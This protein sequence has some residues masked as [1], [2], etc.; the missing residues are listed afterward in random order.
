MRRKLVISIILLIAIAAFSVLAGN[1]AIGTKDI[2]RVIAGGGSLSQQTI[3]FRVRLPRVAAAA[4]CGAALSVA[5]FIIQSTLD[6]RIAS[7]GILG[8]NNGAGLFVLISAL[9][10]PFQSGVKCIMAFA[11]AL[12]VA[13]LVSFLAVRTG[14]SKTSVILSGVAISAIC[15][16]AIELIISLRP[17]TIAD[18]AAFR[19]GGFAAVNPV[20]VLFAIPLIIIG[21]A[22]SFLMAPSMDILNL[23]DEVA[24]GLGLNVRA[25]RNLFIMISALLAAASISMCGLIGFVGLIVPNCVRIISD[26]KSSGGILL[27]ALTGAA[28]LLLCDT[29]SRLIVFPYELPCGLILSIIGAPYLVWILVKKKKRLGID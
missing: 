24:H 19:I 25:C 22:V 4:F 1:G 14:M 13:F 2:L 6:N 3:L 7:P 17:E 16:S 26:K 29:I 28:F 5:G 27:C 9:I 11:G 18:R 23:G 10:F 15:T 12:A 21:L 8:I 20:T